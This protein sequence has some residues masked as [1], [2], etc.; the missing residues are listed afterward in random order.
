MTAISSCVGNPTL[1]PQFIFRFASL[2]DPNLTLADRSAREKTVFSLKKGKFAGLRSPISPAL[3]RNRWKN[4]QLEL[5]HEAIIVDETI[6]S[7]IALGIPCILR[8][9]CYNRY[10]VRVCGY[11]IALHKTGR[12]R[13]D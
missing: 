7:I 13:R 4:D 3:Y 12:S 8:A 5:D 1:T 10:P 6:N 9:R 2:A 11:G